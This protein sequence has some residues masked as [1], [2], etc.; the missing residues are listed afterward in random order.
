MSKMIFVVVPGFILGGVSIVK[1][2]YQ[3]GKSRLDHD[4]CNDKA[5]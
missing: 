2:I 4:Y 3:Q 1:E 5:E